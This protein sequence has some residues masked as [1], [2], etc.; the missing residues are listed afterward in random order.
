MG[1]STQQR[2]ASLKMEQQRGQQRLY[3]TEK[4]QGKVPDDMHKPWS[5]RCPKGMVGEFGE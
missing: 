5:E 2:A 3:E 1:E 4:A